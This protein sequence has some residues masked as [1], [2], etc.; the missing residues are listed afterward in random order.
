MNMGFELQA[1]LGA[2]NWNYSILIWKG[3]DIHYFYYL[4][5]QQKKLFIIKQLFQI[6]HQY[7]N[8]IDADEA[9]SL[10]ARCHFFFLIK[11]A[12]GVLELIPVGIH[13]WQD[14]KP[15][16]WAQTH[17]SPTHGAV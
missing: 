17:C 2:W 16:K 3:L 5:N 9:M 11:V 7:N 1:L 4:F 6:K 10:T 14:S 8:D 13:P 15:S 12:W